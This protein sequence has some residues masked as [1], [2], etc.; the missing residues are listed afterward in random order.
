MG[1]H[2]LGRRRTPDLR[3]Q[4]ARYILLS[5]VPRYGYSSRLMNSYMVLDPLGSQA[6]HRLGHLSRRGG[7]DVMG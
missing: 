6:I 4:G 2:Q 1:V 7:E 5:T 3:Q